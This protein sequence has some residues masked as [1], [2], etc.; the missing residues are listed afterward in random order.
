[1]EKCNNPECNNERAPQRRY[2]Y[3]CKRLKTR[4]SM[5]KK[6]KFCSVDNCNDPVFSKGMC[7][8]HYKRMKYNG[9]V[10][11]LKKRPNG[12]GSFTNGYK[13]HL[14]NG[15]HTL[16]HRAIMAK[17]LGRPL[18][19]DEIVHHRNRNKLDNRV[20]NLIVMNR[21]THKLVCEMENIFS[22]S[23]DK[24]YELFNTINEQFHFNIKFIPK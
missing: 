14:I 1:M 10:D 22:L 11:V 7:A 24:F 23:E 21:T 16:E 15:K 9:N 18:T 8:K 5:I 4:E 6:G 19:K 13:T 17:H 3:K 20:E 12:Q 2:C